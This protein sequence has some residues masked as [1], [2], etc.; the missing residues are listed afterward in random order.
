MFHVY[1]C[2]HTE[3][4]PVSFFISDNKTPGKSNLT[5]EKFKEKVFIVHNDINTE[6]FSLFL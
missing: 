4:S 3:R 5:N 1:H 6:K 2:E